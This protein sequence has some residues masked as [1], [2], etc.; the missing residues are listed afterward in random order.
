M[1]PRN[2]LVPLALKRKAGS[3]TKSTKAIRRK[4]KVDIQRTCSSTG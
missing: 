4:E 2:Y 1:K 3:H